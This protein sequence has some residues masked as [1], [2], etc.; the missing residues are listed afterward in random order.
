M[1]GSGKQ[2]L[3][4]SRERGMTTLGFMILVVFIGLFAFAAIQLTPAYLN[5]IKVAGVLDGVHEEFDGQAPTA[6][7]IRRSISRRFE[8]ESVT[9]ITERDI[10][11][12][13]VDGGF[14]LEAKYDHPTPFLANLYFMV[15]FDKE[16]KIRR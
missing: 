9:V 2:D 12:T 1:E 15:R 16:V 10:K 8:V 4:M 5:Y 14:L 13:Q 11:V 3:A 7:A 6:A